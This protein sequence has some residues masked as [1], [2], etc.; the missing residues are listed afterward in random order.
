MVTSIMKYKQRSQTHKDIK[1]IKDLSLLPNLKIIIKFNH[2]YLKMGADQVTI[3]N[4]L[5]EFKIHYTK[6]I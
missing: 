3:P 1:N 2:R 4:C 6:F 5:H